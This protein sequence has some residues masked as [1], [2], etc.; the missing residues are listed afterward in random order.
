MNYRYV[1][2]TSVFVFL[3]AIT[4][5]YQNCNNK[6]FGN[7]SGSPIL[8]STM[9]SIDGD[10]DTDGTVIVNSCTANETLC[11]DFI[12]VKFYA[13][14]KDLNREPIG[15]VL[16]D[17]VLGTNGE[18]QYKF[19]FTVPKKYACF[20]IKAFAVEP[21]TQI[22]YEIAYS[23]TFKSSS[24]EE[25]CDDG[26]DDPIVVGDPLVDITDVQKEGRLVQIGGKCGV[27]ATVSAPLDFS[28]DI[29]TLIDKRESCP[30]GVFKHCNLINKYQN[31]N[32]V[33]GKQVLNG[34][35]ATDSVMVKWDSLPIK[36]ITFDSF[37]VDADQKNITITGKC[38]PTDIIHLTAYGASGTSTTVTCTASGTYSKK[39]PL[40]IP[41]LK[42]KGRAVTGIGKN[43]AIAGGNSPEIIYDPDKNL[44]PA[45]AITAVVPNANI[46]TKQ[47][48]AFKGTCMASLPVHVSVNGQEQVIGYCSTSGTFDIK[49]VLLQDVGA[50]NVIQIRQVTPYGKSCSDS[51][52]VTSF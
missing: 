41:S 44:Q 23:P 34:K 42:D 33:V 38:N 2:S 49:N 47:A 16:A 39:A 31:D 45:C 48:A 12:K 28:G 29:S 13:Y 6:K 11:P 8:G 3:I 9:N 10:G 15:E 52:T 32:S 14:D 22:E 37:V 5:G 19:S 18:T 35:T 25:K 40:L 26:P 24:F 17:R 51:R 46:C 1:W 30:T 4:L 20:K 7:T 50:S 36:V 27:S 43:S 21:V